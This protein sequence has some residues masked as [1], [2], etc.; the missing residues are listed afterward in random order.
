MANLL[1]AYIPE[2]WANETLA[3]L[4]ENMVSTKLFNND[5]DPQFAKYGD[6]VNTRKP[7]DFKGVRKQKGDNITN[8]D[9]QATNIPVVLNQHVHTSFSIDDLD[10]TMSFK[11]IVAEF[12]EP[13]GIA[14]ARFADRVVNGQVVRF[15]ENGNVMGSR[16]QDVYS[17]IVDAKIY[18]DLKKAPDDPRH[19]L[20]SPNA[21]GKLLKNT[22]M[23]NAEKGPNGRDVAIKG[24]L[25]QLANFDLYPAVNS[26]D[27]PIQAIASK[28]ASGVM[29]A[30]VKG[31]STITATTNSASPALA[32]N[33]TVII[34]GAPYI[35]SG[36]SSLTLT[37]DRPLLNDVAAGST[38][39]VINRAVV[40]ANLVANGGINSG[41]ITFTAATANFMPVVGTMVKLG[42]KWYTLVESHVTTANTFY[43]DR[44]VEDDIAATTAVNCAIGVQ[45]SF[46][47]HKNALTVAMRPLT[48]VPAGAGA[49][50][51][52][53]IFKGNTVRVTF[54][55]DMT[56]QKMICT[57][58]FLMG[59]KVL[60]YDLA[61]MMIS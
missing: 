12:L 32:A 37:L 9:A 48:P 45:G 55:Y 15:Y 23:Y 41:V 16:A 22:N 47:A 54:G 61:A 28:V 7:A 11:N 14:L 36:L 8:Q 17:N 25:G 60:D 50:S 38:F 3:V 46:A 43:L 30:G 24:R 21:H 34:D 44:P 58:D 52:T 35:I 49:R 26:V 40:D 2:W 39:W 29:G 51:F 33:Q 31:S 6:T 19:I 56:T 53:A 5:F 20:L 13:A 18:L 59:V 42:T 57:L 4:Q 1:D 10:T 27:V